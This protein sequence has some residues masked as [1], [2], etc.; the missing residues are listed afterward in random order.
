MEFEI[1][2]VQRDSVTQGRLSPLL[3]VYAGCTPEG[4]KLNNALAWFT[5]KI[6]CKL[7]FQK[8]T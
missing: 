2:A 7:S 8:L 4:N 5:I 1:S 3:P 6:P